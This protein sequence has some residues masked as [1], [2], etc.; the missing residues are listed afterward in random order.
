MNLSEDVLPN[1]LRA[2]DEDRPRLSGIAVSTWP[3][4]W[5]N[6][7][8]D[9]GLITRAEVL[10]SAACECCPEAGYQDVEFVTDGNGRPI[11][12]LCCSFCGPYEI[13]I[14]PLQMWLVPWQP[15]LTAISQTLDITGPG[16]EVVPNRVWRLG[17]GR[18]SG[19]S[20]LVYF[21]RSVHRRDSVSVLQQGAV[22]ENAVVLTPRRQPHPG[23][24]QRVVQLELALNCG[25]DGFIADHDYLASAV[26]QSVAESDSPP[27]VRKRG[28][29]LVLIEQLTQEMRQHLQGARDHIA[30]ALDHDREPTLLPRPTQKQLAKRFGVDNGS[31]C[32]C[33][34]DPTA[35][36]LQ[37]LWNMASDLDAILRQMPQS[38]R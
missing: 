14:E 31:V 25:D 32:R 36:E 18:W 8:L 6:T 38:R 13:A 23:V 7:V 1:L 24:A 20:H 9:M 27:P 26:E 22:P 12:L 21:M 16:R 11:A 28:T 10:T 19:R 2:V 33:L 4:D 35:T 30:A 29:R 34:Q 17:K 15:F 5:K 3:T 37:Y